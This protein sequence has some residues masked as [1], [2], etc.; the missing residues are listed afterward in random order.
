MAGEQ[1]LLA[2][3]VT[4]TANRIASARLVYADG[5]AATGA[6]PLSEGELFVPG[7]AVEILAGPSNDQ[8]LLFTGIVVRQSLKIRDRATPQ[9]VVECRHKAVKLTVG[10]KNSYFRDQNDSDIVTG[11]VEGAGLEAKVEATSFTLKQQ[12][13]YDCTD[14][15]FLLMRAEANGL[16]VFTNR[17]EVE[18]K[19]PAMDGSPVCTLLFGAT[20]L[21]MDVQMEARGQYQ[22]VTG[23][24]WD[25]AS[26]EIVAKEA[27]DPGIAALGNHDAGQLAQV[28][29]LDGFRLQHGAVAAEEAQAWADAQWLK[30][31]LSRITGRI[32]CEGIGTVEPGDIVTLDGV[33]GRFNGNA[34]VSGVRHDFD[35]AQGW[36][37]HLQFGGLDGWLGRE[38]QVTAPK[39]GA[40][41]PGINGLQLGVVTGNEDPDGE[42]RV[43]VRMPLVSGDEDG[44]WCRVAMLDAGNERG[45]FFRPEIGDEVVLGF[46]NDDPRQAVILGMLH[47]SAKPAPLAGSDDNHEKVYQS[48]SGMKLS[49]N[50]DTKVIRLET[51]SGNAITLSEDEQGIAI[52]DQNGNTLAMNQDGIA[53]ESCKALTLKAATEL[54]IEA[55]AA[56]TIKSGAELKLEGS[57]GCE[58]LSGGIAKVKGSMVQIN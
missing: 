11:L 8:V 21:E 1:H 24:T 55:S 26:Q 27:V 51:P 16:L 17:A 45:F 30:S 9:L 23:V 29:G 2:V 12:A 41:V 18:V 6:F 4:K 33:G 44:L 40:L 3:S 25:A 35:L 20:I 56:G 54:L 32:K 5:A 38:H 31:Q 58:L 22:A 42:H 50:D 43:R 49:F 48:R 36:K 14:W 15:D 57:G 34:Y 28:V 53:I 19:A 37:T 10:A 47:S 7:K 46:V 39:A 13:Q 52:A